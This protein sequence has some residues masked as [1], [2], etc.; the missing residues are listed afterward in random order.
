MLN[1]KH[2]YTNIYNLIRIGIGKLTRGVKAVGKSKVKPKIVRLLVIL[3][4]T[5]YS[6][7]LMD[8]SCASLSCCLFHSPP[9]HK[10]ISRH[11]KYLLNVQLRQLCIIISDCIN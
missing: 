3:N 9:Y 10:F 8:L 4:M 2:K 11:Y 6:S 1:L 5:M 7:S